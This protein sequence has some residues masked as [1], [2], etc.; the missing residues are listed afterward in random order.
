MSLPPASAADNP[1][2][3]G[4]EAPAPLPDVLDL[5]P[6]A[7]ATRLP[8]P[9]PSRLPQ[10]L[11]WST[12]T[13]I[14]AMVGVLVVVCGASGAY[15]LVRDP[16][17][18][19]RTDLVTHRV[20]YERLEL[21]IVERGALESA[22]NSD[23]YCTVKASQKGGTV[24]STIKWLIDDGSQVK[25]GEL[26]VDLDDS[27]LQDQLKNERI[28]LDKN[29]ADKI[30]AEEN[31][32]I[33]DSQ[34]ESD[35]KTA[36]VNL[37]LAEIDLQKYKEGDYPQQLKI[38]EGNI[39]QAES[40]VE[41]Q[42]DR[43]AWANR[44]VKKGYLTVTQAQGEQ[45]KM[46]SLEISLAKATEDRRVLTDPVFGTGKR[47]VT[48]LQNGVA[49]AKRA[50]ERVKSQAKAKE[51]QARSDR[52]ATKSVYVQ[53]LA[54][55]KEIEDEIKK[56]KIYA[57]QDGMVVYFVPEQARGGGGSQQAIIAQ[58]EPVREGQK[59]MQIPD[60]RAMLVNTKVHE[61]LV[62]RVA[63]GQPARVR[64]DSFPDLV[65]SGHVDTVA[66]VSSQQDFFSADVKVYTTKVRIDQSLEGLKPGMSAEVTITVAD[67]LDRVLTVPIQAIVGGAEMGKQRKCYVV[68]PQGPQERDI[69]VGQSN[70]KLAEIKQGLKEGDEVVLNPRVLVGDKA[71]VRQPGKERP[72]SSAGAPGEGSKL[73]RASGKD[74]P[75]GA[76]PA[77]DKAR[78]PN[79]ETSG[80]GAPSPEERQKRQQEMTEK[81]RK[82]TPEERK[83]MLEQIPE[84]FRDKVREKLKEQGLE[85][86]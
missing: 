69:V 26:L 20:H 85:I 39:K 45:S 66:T 19:T 29:E 63:S 28:T 40:D 55:C 10:P 76:R 30:K 34:N 49:E 57:P 43:V 80:D 11:R 68:T 6:V 74:Q 32:K 58:G 51:I 61:A 22:K 16:F 18:R 37:E 46:E 59:L 44:M 60:L 17:Q 4:A 56:C 1:T 53:Q 25:K 78:G 73:P 48:F 2:S 38:F 77:P 35:I 54:R 31:Y 7:S 36:E 65:L 71:K 47:Q 52:E 84:T 13:K 67:A 62:S 72:D 75:K 12:R 64:V 86:K 27:G 42:R 82:A 15:L 3:S 5:A 83:Q 81:F 14:L 8:D 21:N 41:Q 50:L 9:A 79:A 70:E 23:I 33:V 24:A